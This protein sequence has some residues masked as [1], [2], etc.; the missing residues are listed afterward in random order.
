MLEM[1]I[2]KLVHARDLEKDKYYEA[3]KECADMLSMICM[4]GMGLGTRVLSTDVYV[5]RN[6]TLEE[7]LEEIW[8][9]INELQKGGNNADG[10]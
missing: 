3:V 5:A 2:D 10:C 6:E 9:A 4:D 7:H 8:L 1:V